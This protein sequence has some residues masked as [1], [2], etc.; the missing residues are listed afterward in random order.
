MN[1]NINNLNGDKRQVEASKNDKNFIF[2][3]LSGKGG[4]MG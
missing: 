3:M 4:G 1:T 2:V